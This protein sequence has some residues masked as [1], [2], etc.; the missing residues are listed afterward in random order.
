MSYII[1][2]TSALINTLL[3]DAARK[4]ISQG[5]FDIAY[6]QIGDSEVC[7]NCLDN[8]NPV[9]FNVLMPQY[10][11][12]NT[13]PIPEKNRMHVKY[14]LFLDSTSGSTF[15]VPFDNS[16]I[17]NVYNSAAPRGFFTGDTINGFSAFTSSAYTIN[18]NF[19]AD[20]TTISG[21]VITL[22]ATTLYPT[23]SGSVTQGMY[24]VMFVNNSLEPITSNSP[25]F[26]YSVVS[27]TGDSSTATTIN[28]EVDRTL[29]NYALMG[30]SGYSS[31]MFLPE[32]MTDLYD[33]FTPQPYWATDVFNFETNCD[34]SQRNVNVWNMNIPWT[35]SPAGIFESS[36]QDYNYYKSTAYTN[37]KEYLG[38]NNKNGQEDTSESFYYNS[39][40]EKITVPSTDQKAIAIVHYTN[41]SIDNFYGEKF[42]FQEYD[43]TNPGNTGQARNFKISLPWLLWHKNTSGTTGEDFY[44]DPP[45]FSNIDLFQVYYVESKKDISFNNRGL[46]YYHLW[47]THANINGI[48]NRVGKV[49][50]DLKMVVF[51]DDEIVASLNYK[52]NRTWTLPAPKL[53]LVTP[54]TF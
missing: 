36:Y 44:V 31:V 52:S 24:M 25:M 20:N 45:G 22:S 33:T 32:K 12:Q 7:Y 27:V 19:V 42:A 13:S 50:P 29:P 37:T 11:A 54:N 15:G 30:Y 21:S 46:R 5:K 18:S 16:Y 35:E 40:F 48:P 53:G 3:T 38:Y 23:V 43:P 14:P 9:D 4:R 28:I 51:D 49:F 39:F 26:I 2:N 1:K 6:F 10:N 8:F 41:Q 47:D 34:I 17:D